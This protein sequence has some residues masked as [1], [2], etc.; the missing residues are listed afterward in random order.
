[1][2]NDSTISSFESLI[3]DPLKPRP[4]KSGPEI[5]C[6]CHETR[7]APEEVDHP[8]D[9][10]PFQDIPQPSL[11]SAKSTSP[12]N[13]AEIRSTTHL[14]Q[15]FKCRFEGCDKAYLN[16]SSE[17]RHSSEHKK[18]MYRCRFCCS[19]DFTRLDNRKTHER[20]YHKG[21]PP[22]SVSKHDWSKLRREPT[23][24]QSES[25]PS[26]GYARIPKQ[27]ERRATMC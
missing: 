2:V 14:R 3:P 5:P 22:T 27:R 26:V 20:K 6:D 9:P 25:T 8:K 1:M 4:K 24:R 10:L 13:S 19:T 12:G 16:K 11:A 23:S 17:S 18:Q 15:K 7:I 21:E